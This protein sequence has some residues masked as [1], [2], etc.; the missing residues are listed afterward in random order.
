[1]VGDVLAGGGV[2]AS[3]RDEALEKDKAFYI[4]MAA[5]DSYY[6]K[7]KNA[8]FIVWNDGEGFIDSAPDVVEVYP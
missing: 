5:R 3:N 6:E 8:E 7:Y 1:M 4:E 2:L